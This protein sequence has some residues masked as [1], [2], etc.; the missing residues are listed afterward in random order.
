[1]SGDG[2]KVAIAQVY[3]NRREDKKQYFIGEID[4][5]PTGTVKIDTEE[6]CFSDAAEADGFVPLGSDC[7][8]DDPLRPS[9]C[10]T[11]V[12]TNNEVCFNT[13]TSDTVN[14][15]SF[16]KGFTSVC[17]VPD[18]NVKIYKKVCTLTL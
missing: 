7:S 3:A 6:E 8:V 4:S 14:E 11:D 9:G 12:N 1:M 16:P 15:S 17:K 13:A 5:C 18:S 10:F 2:S